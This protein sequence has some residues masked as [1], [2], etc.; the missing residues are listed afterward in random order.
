M[1]RNSF[2]SP[3]SSHALHAGVANH[4]RIMAKFTC[5]GIWPSASYI[6]HACVSN[7]RRSFIGDMMIVRAAQ[8]LPANTELT[9][10]YK[11]P[12]N[13]Y[14][15]DTSH[16]GFECSCALCR[17][18]RGTAGHVRRRRVHLRARIW[19]SVRRNHSLERDEIE[20]LLRELAGT[21]V[22]SA[23]VAPH[24]A[25]GDLHFAVARLFSRDGD[26]E[27]GIGYTM[28]GFEAL[29]FEI[30]GF[31]PRGELLVKRWGVVIDEQVGAWVLLYIAFLEVAPELAEMADH[32]ARLTYKICVGEEDSFDDIYG[33]R[34]G[35][36][37][38][39]ID[40]EG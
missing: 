7:V 26:T 8:D 35:K 16:W 3:I 12:S 9:F 40:L 33:K 27:K 23:R 2:G 34:S 13:A 24:F 38:G 6:N 17:N 25:I 5:L 15:T 1:N 39:P 21:Y 10:W 22:E 19:S 36:P 31:E 32:Y 37:Y 14:L 11:V 18:V 28:K 20:E 30:E 29:G 4:L